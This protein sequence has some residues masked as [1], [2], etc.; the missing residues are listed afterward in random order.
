MNIR[1]RSLDYRGSHCM[2]L[3]KRGMFLLPVNHSR[4]TKETIMNIRNR[5][6]AFCTMLLLGTA[7]FLGGCATTGMDRSAKTSNSIQDVDNE[8]RKMVVQSDATAASL[9]VLI[10]PAQSDLKK[11]FDSYTKNVA[12]LD[13]EGKRVFKRIDE[14]KANGTEYFAEWEK[15]GDT[16]TNQRI[17]ELSEERRAKLAEVY[18]QVHVAGA[19]IKGS[20]NAYLADLKE[21]QKFLSNDL[22][23]KG[24][25]SITPVANK[26]FQDLDVLKESVKPVISALDAIKAELYVD[27]K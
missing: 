10:K 9:E 12:D 6:L 26:S 19:G 24:V 27:K 3:F 11:S 4:I 5:S 18:A 7:A 13:S 20:Y 23:P 25:E 16:Y 2:E 17:R 8:I 1:N 21:I 15:Q 14:M 22:T